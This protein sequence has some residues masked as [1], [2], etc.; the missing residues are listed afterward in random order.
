MR[1]L[2]YISA[3]SAI[4]VFACTVFAAPTYGD[5]SPS[6][7][8]YISGRT[9]PTLGILDPSKMTISHNIQM[10]FASFGGGSMMQ[11]LYATTVGYQLSNP[12]TLNVTMGLAG[13]RYNFGG[14]PMTYNSLIGGATLDYRPSK[15]V[16]FRLS[17]NHGPGLYQSSYYDNQAGFSAG[18][19]VF[20]EKSETG[21]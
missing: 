20:G 19:Q 1:K 3:I 8:D 14:A 2:Q 11:S 4:L 12:L 13:T 17:F 16:F 9:M 6:L 5:G 7:R 21:R 15:D 10:G 18:A